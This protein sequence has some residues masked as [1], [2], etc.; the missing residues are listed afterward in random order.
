MQ[1][2]SYRTSTE[3]TDAE[4]RWAERNRCLENEVL[5]DYLEREY[6]SRDILLSLALSE[7]RQRSFVL[8]GRTPSE[9]ELI[10]AEERHVLRYMTAGIF[11]GCASCYSPVV[12]FAD[13]F[14]L[15]WPAREPHRC[16]G[17]AYTTSPAR[18]TSSSSSALSVLRG[19]P[20]NR[21][22]A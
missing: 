4:A 20:R 19:T 13:G 12:T 6:S 10:D 1:E 11:G 18:R 21:V 22:S 5:L 9:Q 8:A 3:P 16:Q 2:Q 14:Q 17:L 7:S 15:D